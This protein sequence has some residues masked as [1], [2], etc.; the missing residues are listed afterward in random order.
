MAG[1]EGGAQRPTVFGGIE[2]SAPQGARRRFEARRRRAARVDIEREVQHVTA[3]IAAVPAVR[4][5]SIS[6]GAALIPSH[7]F[8]HGRLLDLRMQRLERDLDHL[9]AKLLLSVRREIRIAERIRDRFT[10]DDAVRADR[11]REPR[12]RGHDDGRDSGSF[13]LLRQRRPATRSCPSGAADDGSV[14]PD[15]SHVL[16]HFAPDPLHLRDR[17]H[18]SARGVDGVADRDLPF[19]LERPQHAQR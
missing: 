14:D 4:T 19:S 11:L 12:D 6:G 2:V 3:R 8:K 16:G 10:S 17:A 18:V 1:G 15:P 7:A 5:G 13:E 9:P